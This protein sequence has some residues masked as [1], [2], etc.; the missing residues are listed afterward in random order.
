MADSGIRHLFDE[1]NLTEKTAFSL[2]K[3]KD[4]YILDITVQERYNFGI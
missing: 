4:D 1:L 3:T 2:E